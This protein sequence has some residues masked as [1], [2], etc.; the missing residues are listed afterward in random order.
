MTE[1]KLK[2]QNNRKPELQY[3]NEFQGRIKSYSLVT[4]SFNVYY[5]PLLVSYLLSNCIIQIK[6]TYGLKHL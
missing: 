2:L 1:D 4:K 6:F 3:S 5:L